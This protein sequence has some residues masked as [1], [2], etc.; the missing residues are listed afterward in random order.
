MLAGL[1][2]LLAAGRL[3]QPADYFLGAGWIVILAA[4]SQ[5]SR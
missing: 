4:V 5:L 1:R 3:S 2:K